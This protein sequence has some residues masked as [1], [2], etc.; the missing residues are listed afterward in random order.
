MEKIL[1]LANKINLPD[2]LI[3]KLSELDMNKIKTIY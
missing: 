2:E 3:N 1:Q